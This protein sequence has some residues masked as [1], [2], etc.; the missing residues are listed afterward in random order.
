MQS[1]TAVSCGKNMKNQMKIYKKQLTH[2]GQY[3]IISQCDVVRKCLAKAPEKV[4]YI[5]DNY[6]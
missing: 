1:K 5:I 6:S 3:N 2:T 4:F